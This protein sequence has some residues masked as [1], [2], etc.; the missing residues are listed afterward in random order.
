MSDGKL[1]EKTA[2]ITGGASGIGAE[3]ARRMAAEGAR[4]VVAD[5]QE[6]KAETL[7]LSLGDAALAVPLDV[8]DDANWS[9]A[10]GAAEKHFGPFHILVNAAGISV[11]ATIEDADLA[12]WHH[13]MGVNADGT[14]LGCKHGVAALKKAG[15][16]AIVNIASTLGVRAGAM[17]T[18]YAASKGAVRM[19]T[20]AVALHCAEQKLNIRVNAVLPGAIETPMYERYIDQGVAAGARREDIEAQYAAGHPLGRVGAPQEV[21]EAILFLA[22]DSASFITG[23]DL[24]VDGG[25]LA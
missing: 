16:G 17:F 7:A 21:A 15:G 14:F 1:A 20:R 19:L 23:V 5:R 11:P 8:T 18:A 4:V 25:F 2:F 24:P 3:T 22:S 10:I 6:E 12:H 13:V 9:A